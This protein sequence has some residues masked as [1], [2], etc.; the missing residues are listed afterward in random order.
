M[1]T[2]EKLFPRPMRGDLGGQVLFVVLAITVALVA[3][4]N[5]VVPESSSL[6]LST[7]AVTL[8]GTASTRTN[9]PSAASFR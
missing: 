3:F 8:I 4:L 5:L 2:L 1:G 9:R 6:H 7:Y